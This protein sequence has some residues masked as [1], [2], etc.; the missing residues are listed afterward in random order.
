[1][2]GDREGSRRRSHRHAGRGDAARACMRATPRRTVDQDAPAARLRRIL[3]ARDTAL[4]GIAIVIFLFF[5]LMA[6]HFLSKFNLFNTLRSISLISIVAVG[7]TY[8]LVAGEIDL[9]VG[10]MH[11]VLTVSM[12]L[13]V[14]TAGLSPWLAMPLIVLLGLLLGTVNGLIVV[15]IG[16]PSF[17]V[18]LAML[19]G[20]RSAALLLTNERP[21][22]SRGRELFYRVT[23]GD[24][25]GEVPWLIIWMLVVVTI[26]GIVLARTRFGSHVYAVGG[27]PEAARNAG[28]DLARV[29]LRC[30]MLTGALCGLVSALLFGYLRVAGP[31]AGTGFEFRVIGAAVVGGVAL[32]GGRGSVF[33][34]LMG[35][36]IIGMITSGMVLLG[37]SQNIGDV[38]AGLLII[39]VGSLDILLRRHA[40]RAG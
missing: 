32:S 31:T 34:S 28:I 1:M 3:L 18:T 40:R 36:L 26:G 9:S 39:V 7:I 13:L 33:G 12:G 6:P 35:A 14:V 11:G 25:M 30:F 22:A 29:K 21:L 15:R 5:A 10:S 24:L 2:T 17:I 4:V 23:G 16:I 19:V 37:F 27:N 38:A 20:Y 8:L